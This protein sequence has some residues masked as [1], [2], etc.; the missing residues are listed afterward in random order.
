MCCTFRVTVTDTVTDTVTGS[1]TDGEGNRVTDADD[2]VVTVGKTP[3][4][5]PQPPEPPV[6]PAGDPEVDLQVAKTQPA[7]AFVGLG[8]SAWTT[9]IRVTNAGPD[10][11]PGT[12]LDDAAP[13][14]MRFLRISEPPSQGTCVI[15][16]RG[17][18]LHCDLGTVGGHQTVGVR[19]LV[20]VTGN[21]GDSITNNAAAACTAAGPDECAAVAGATTRLLAGAPPSCAAIT[22]RPSTLVVDGAPTTLTLLVRRSGAPVRD[23]SVLVVGPGIRTVVRTGADGRA[24]AT[25]T[26]TSAGTVRATLVRSLACPPGEARILPG[27]TG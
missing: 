9:D 5:Q 10:P 14:N 19:V 8:L 17:R 24:R 25:V 13:K 21:V 4:P 15:R 22:I 16:D 3:P 26:P 27:V 18:T 20:G 2:A 11:A 7:T 6:N 12:T 23:A 1:G